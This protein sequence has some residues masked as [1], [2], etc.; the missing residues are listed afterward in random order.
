MYKAHI[1]NNTTKI[2][3]FSNID[4]IYRMAKN[5]D[6]SGI[7]MENRHLLYME[8]LTLSLM[9]LFGITTNGCH[10]LTSI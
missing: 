4:D 3:N 10:Y 8:M 7:T 9:Y 6:N 5:T 2:V 1:K